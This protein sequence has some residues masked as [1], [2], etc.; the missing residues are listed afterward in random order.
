MNNLEDLERSE[1]VVGDVIPVRE[2]V[3]E[4]EWCNTKSP[5]IYSYYNFFDGAE[6][7]SGSAYLHNE[8]L[9]RED[10]SED[11]ILIRWRGITEEAYKNFIEES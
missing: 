9:D 10:L 8:P 11:W 5:V 7:K 1:W 3:Y 6:W 4:C 2:G